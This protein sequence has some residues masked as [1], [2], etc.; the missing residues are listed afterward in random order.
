MEIIA[1]STPAKIEK[2]VAIKPNTPV[3][4]LNL[5]PKNQVAMID[6]TIAPMIEAMRAYAIF[7][8]FAVASCMIKPC[9]KI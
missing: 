4:L 7:L 1:I 3:S 6:S 5:D 8:T 2:I 9:S